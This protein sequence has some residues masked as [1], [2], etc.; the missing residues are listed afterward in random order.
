MIV[1]MSYRDSCS[2]ILIE[3]DG[4]LCCERL[5]TFLHVLHSLTLLTQWGHKSGANYVAL[6]PKETQSCEFYNNQ[7]RCFTSSLFKQ[8][9]IWFHQTNLLLSIGTDLSSY[10]KKEGTSSVRDMYFVGNK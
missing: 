7:F 4:F 3:S 6:F 1:P 8:T 2:L 9:N 10:F 5:N